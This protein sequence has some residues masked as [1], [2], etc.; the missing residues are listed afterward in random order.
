MDRLTGKNNDYC[1]FTCGDRN[2]RIREECNLYNVC[3][4][5]KM[6][7]KLKHYEDLE[8]T[9]RLLVLPEELNREKFLEN[10]AAFMCPGWAAGLPDWHET[11][12][13]SHNTVKDVCI[14]CW[15][16]ALKGE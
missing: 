12:A 15:E 9:G 8:E 13:C 1:F 14:K 7:E 5:R 11:D 10:I 2:T 4:E 6:Y 16:A 3:Y